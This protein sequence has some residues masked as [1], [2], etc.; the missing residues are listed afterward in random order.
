MVQGL[1]DM[2]TFRLEMLGFGLWDK[3]VDAVTQDGDA[4]WIGGIQNHD[5]PAGITEWL[6]PNGKPS[7]FE[8]NLL[9]G[10]DNDEITS[11]AIDD[12]TVWLGTHDGLTRY[13]R[14]KN[15]WRTYTVVDNLVNN[16]VYDLLVDDEA[17]WV[18]TEA[19][20]SKVLKKT[21]GT[22]SMVIQ[23]VLY[24]SLRNLQVFDLDQN[25]N[26]IYMGTELGLFVYDKNKDD[27]HFYSSDV[28]PVDE[29]IYALSAYKNEL[30]YGTETGVS[31]FNTATG[32]R[33][34]PPARLNE[35]DLD[36][37]KI[38]ATEDAVWVA[39][40]SGVLKYDRHNERWVF[41]TMKDGL[42][43]NHVYSLYLDGDYIW[44]GTDSGLTKFY[45]NSPYR[46]D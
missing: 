9:T 22:D 45:W 13:D 12:H 34:D 1:G 20:V 40:D 30:W 25:K 14:E 24:P 33:F 42:A 10:F 41:Y 28:D 5:E 36:I 17:I 38:L 21:V 16:S 11:L 31:G 26:V 46:I 23:H 27:G 3:A 43:S 2:A 39:S 6:I 32:N 29:S 4:F 8:A 18:A 19:G 35:N 44:F 7:Y 15:I 37:N